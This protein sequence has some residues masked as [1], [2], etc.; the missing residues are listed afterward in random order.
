MY[1]LL[2]QL[3]LPFDFVLAPL[4]S[5]WPLSEDDAAGTALLCLILRIAASRWATCSSTAVCAAR[6]V[7]HPGLA[8]SRLQHSRCEALILSCY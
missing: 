8:N 6:S 1:S 7:L 2:A 3:W 5:M 4:Q